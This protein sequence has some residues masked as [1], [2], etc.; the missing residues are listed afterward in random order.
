M[1]DFRY[2]PVEFYLVGLEGDRPE[3]GVVAALVNLLDTGMVRL[4]DFVI[5]SKDDDGEVTVTEV[6][7]EDDR[8]GL[9]ETE[10]SASG[11]VGDEDV[12]E[13]AE[14]I[15]P[16]ASAALVAFELVY[17]RDL[18]SRL[19]ASGAV[20]LASDRVPAPVVNALMDALDDAEQDPWPVSLVYPQ[21]GLMPLKVRAFLDFAAPRLRER[22][23][24]L[25]GP[26]APANVVAR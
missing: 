18:A 20:V 26:K 16:G 19:A 13:L 21:R 9:G 4:L 17:Q 7:D 1:V 15:P 3:P 23:G 2:G 8:Y 25:N 14:L 6:E 5:L 12:A 22:L 24:G 10:L 11:I